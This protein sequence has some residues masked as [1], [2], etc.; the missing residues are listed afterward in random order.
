MDLKEWLATL[1]AAI[2]TDDVPLGEDTLHTLLD[3][4]R[5]SAHGV[6]RV[7]APLTTYLVG[8]AVGRGASLDSVASTATALA[9]GGTT[10]GQGQQVPGRGAAGEGRAD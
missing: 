6:E 9:V 10:G 5:D 3:L 8:V 7:A 1:S 4:A 2:G